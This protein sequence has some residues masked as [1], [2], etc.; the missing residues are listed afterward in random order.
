MNPKIINIVKLSPRESEIM[1]L[2][3]EGL[4][5]KEIVSRL[6]S[7]YTT[8]RTHLTRIYGKMEVRS[9]TEAVVKYLRC[10][11]VGFTRQVPRS[12]TRFSI[13]VGDF[14]S[15]SARIG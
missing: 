9:R 4:T 15:E 3:A 11:P 14:Q 5:D 6:S 10:R 12:R 7:N 13:T 8:V 1:A 2:L